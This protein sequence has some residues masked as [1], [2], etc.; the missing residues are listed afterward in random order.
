[1]QKQLLTELAESRAAHEVQRHAAATDWPDIADLIQQDLTTANDTVIYQQQPNA[2]IQAYA[3]S[4]IGMGAVCN[5][6]P[7]HCLGASTAPAIVKQ[8]SHDRTAHNIRYQTCNTHL[9]QHGSGMSGMQLPAAFATYPDAAVHPDTAINSNMADDVNRKTHL[10][11]SKRKRNQEAF[12]EQ[13]SVGLEDDREIQPETP[14]QGDQARGR[15]T[16]RRI[17][18]SN[19]EGTSIARP[20]AGDIVWAKVLNHPFWPA[21]VSIRH[22]VYSIR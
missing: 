22:M 16:F 6:K 12:T 13:S 2:V 15:A 19:S 21:Q 5:A 7:P 11:T 1:M 4:T 10:S 8:H 9:Q 18:N 14:E 20:K 17:D 3:N